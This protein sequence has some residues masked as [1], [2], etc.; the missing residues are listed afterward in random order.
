[1]RRESPVVPMPKGI[2]LRK[3]GHPEHLQQVIGTKKAV[4]AVEKAWNP[5][6]NPPVSRPP[7]S[8]VVGKN[9]QQKFDRTLGTALGY[10]PVKVGRYSHVTA[11]PHLYKKGPPGFYTRTGPVPLRDRV[12]E[13]KDMYQSYAPWAKNPYLK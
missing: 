13:L 9:I 7:I 11:N 8:D 12:T 6:H 5:F 3:L 4:E 10:D 2:E 1:M